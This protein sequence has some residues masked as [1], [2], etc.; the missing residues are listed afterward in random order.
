MALLDLLDH[1]VH[2]A[3]PGGVTTYAIHGSQ[4]PQVIPV[5]STTGAN[6]G[7]WIVFNQKP[8]TGYESMCDLRIT[9]VDTVNK[10]I[11]CVCTNNF[12]N[13]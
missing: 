2:V 4:N 11:T 5:A 3:V 7:D 10:T 9:A 13:E 8:P 6:V 12:S 1:K